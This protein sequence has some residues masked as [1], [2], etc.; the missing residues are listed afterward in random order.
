MLL[1][2]AGAI[3]A[4]LSPWLL[5]SALALVLGGIGLGILFP[6][7]T[8]SAFTLA[9]GQAHT[10]SAP[11]VLAIGIA[12]LTAPL[13]VGIAADTFGILSAWLLVPVICAL[14]LALSIPVARSL[15][16]PHQI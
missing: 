15:R 11:I 7:A 2:A 6:L 12:M 1:V 10:A 8:T 5:V 13:V 4:W 16:T 14:A 3:A 9:P